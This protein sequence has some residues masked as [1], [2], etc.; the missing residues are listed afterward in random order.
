M[1]FARLLSAHLEKLNVLRR[2]EFYFQHPSFLQSRRKRQRRRGRKQAG[3][4]QRLRLRGTDSATL[5]VDES[6]VS[7]AVTSRQRTL[8][9]MSFVK[10]RLPCRDAVHRRLISIVKS[11]RDDNTSPQQMCLSADGRR[12]V[13]RSDVFQ[14]LRDPVAPVSLSESSRSPRRRQTLLPCFR[15]TSFPVYSRRRVSPSLPELAHALSSTQRRIHLFF[16]SNN[17]SHSHSHHCHC[18]IK[19]KT[20]SARHIKKALHRR[21]RRHASVETPSADNPEDPGG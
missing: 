6:E 8:T 5:L 11:C 10:T 3:R 4:R 14:L 21:N 9:G 12:I 20:T 7:S 16:N 18:K 15:F 1:S 19:R 2:A 13:P 17:C